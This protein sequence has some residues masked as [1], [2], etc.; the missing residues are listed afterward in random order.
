MTTSASVL[1]CFRKRHL[2]WIHRL[3]STYSLYRNR[4]IYI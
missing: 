1:A 4:N 3:S 2:S